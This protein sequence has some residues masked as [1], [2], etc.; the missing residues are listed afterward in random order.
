MRRRRRNG[1]SLPSNLVTKLATALGVTVAVS[2]LDI[3]YLTYITAHGFAIK[4]KLFDVGGLKFVIPVQWLPVAGVVLVSLV[5]WY[6]VSS[7]VFPRRSGL[8]I[9]HL[10]SY[11]LMRIIAISLAAFVCLLYVPY[12]LG[13]NWFW[14][15]LSS[16][17]SISQ[18]R[19][20][21]ISILNTDQSM[22]ALDPLWQYA[23]SQ[24]V[25]LAGMLCCAWYFSRLP[26]RVKKPVR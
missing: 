3:F 19:D 12:I 16:A 5:A 11:R 13:S 22:M 24:F 20:F 18:V 7:T 4:T 6:E 10:A 2:L 1:V 14:T 21:A 23:V 8:E 26:R 17:S 25:A 9:D 15:K